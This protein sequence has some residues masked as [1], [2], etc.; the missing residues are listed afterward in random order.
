MSSGT[1]STGDAIAALLRRFT[2]LEVLNEDP[3]SKTAWLLG[4][5]DDEDGASASAVV[6]V[7]RPPFSLGGAGPGL[8]HG[9][10]LGEGEQNDIY[11]W[12]TGFANSA[13]LGPD[14]R[15]SVIYPATE[16][17]T[18]KHRRQQRRWVCETPQLYAQ[19]VQPYVDAQPAA[20]LRWVENI[21]DKRVEAER[22]VYEDPD[23]ETGFVIL[24]DLKWDTADAASMYLVAIVHRRGIRSLR[25]LTAAHLPLL[26][27]IRAKAAIAAQRYNVPADA[28]R[29]YI[30]YQPSYYHLHV[31][32]TNVALESRG[33]SVDRAHLLDTVI[34]NIEDIAPDYYQRATLSYV[35]GA[36]SE[37]W[38]RWTA[39]SG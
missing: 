15:V 7:E 20:R 18:S 38:S 2:P 5:I 35:L 36:D 30:H 11:S 14:L 19:I 23:R 26:K 39:H 27:N 32:I 31:H 3:S 6:T 10:A 25:D 37:L 8:F 29:L 13:A 22:I 1:A 33:M 17:H 24:P 12:A 9:I 34:A 21:L 28:L 16:K 4:R